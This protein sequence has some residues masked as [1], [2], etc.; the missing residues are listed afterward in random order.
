MA[1][2][3]ARMPKIRTR[4]QA[5]SPVSEKSTVDV[6]KHTAAAKKH[7]AEPVAPSH[8]KANAVAAT[9]TNANISTS[10]HLVADKLG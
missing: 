5:T 10:V 8:A 9:A 4:P 1:K 2:I 3:K 6:R 7:T